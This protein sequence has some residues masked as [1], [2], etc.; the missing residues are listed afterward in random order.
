LCVSHC[1][2]VAYAQVP[3]ID[4]EVAAII[5]PQPRCRMLFK[6]NGKSGKIRVNVMDEIRD[7]NVSSWESGELYSDVEVKKFNSSDLEIAENDKL[8]FFMREILSSEDDDSLILV[9]LRDQRR[10]Q[11]DWEWDKLITDDEMKRFLKKQGIYLITEFTIKV[12]SDCNNKIGASGIKS[13]KVADF[14][15]DCSF[16]FN[17]CFCDESG[18]ERSKPGCDCYDAGN[19]HADQRFPG[20]YHCEKCPFGYMGEHCQKSIFF[21]GMLAIAIISLTSLVG[22][23]LAPMRSWPIYPD[24][25]S[26][27]VALAIGCL[28]GD[29]VLHLIPIIFGL[30]DHEH[31]EEHSEHEDHHEH[32]A[33]GQEEEEDGL[34]HKMI[35]KRGLMLLLGLYTFYLFE[36]GIGLWH[37]FKLSRQESSD[38]EIG[39]RRKSSRSRHFSRTF[40]E[41]GGPGHKLSIIEDRNHEVC[42]D[43]KCNSNTDDV[44]LNPSEG[45]AML[46]N[47]QEMLIKNGNGNPASSHSHGHSHGR[48]S[49]VAL[50]GWM[51]IVGDAFHNF[52]DGLA[53]GAAFSASYSIGLGTVFAVFFHELPHEIGDFAV[54][55]SSGFTVKK[56]MFWNLVS[57]FTCFIGFFVGT[58]LGDTEEFKIWILA[59]SAG[60][61]VYIALVDMLPEIR[62]TALPEGDAST[63]VR[64]FIVQQ[65]GL[66]SGVLLMW[67]LAVFEEDLVAIFQ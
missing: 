51:I 32:D 33:H 45:T 3:D 61:F 21:T 54:L 57:S 2:A 5:E 1:L 35:T 24:L 8:G 48:K 15:K 59:I 67:L 53:I 30:H 36:T 18:D 10:R 44:F 27:M 25:Q 41:S 22:A 17:K 49:D 26:G 63:M 37:S 12:L 46:E 20:G 62:L 13:N 58:L 9:Y 55:L 52:A 19:C 6:K 7:L 42:I 50:V 65:A 56:A 23:V 16:D 28:S 11:L 64:R 40:S 31:G 60:A 66:I 43:E 4:I 39:S 14:M 47:A 29:A 34:S 38:N